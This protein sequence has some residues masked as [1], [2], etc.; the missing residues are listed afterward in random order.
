MGLLRKLIAVGEA[1]GVI[2]IALI[3]AVVVYDVTARAAGHPTL[4]AL[5]VSGY[6]MVAAS[7]LAAGEVMQKGGHF[8]VRLFLDMLPQSLRSAIDRLVAIVTAVFAVCITAGCVQLVLQT[9]ALGFR[10]PTLLQ[11]PLVVPQSVLLL[12][13]ALLSVAALLRAIAQWRESRTG[14]EGEIAP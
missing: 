3:A 11:V 8:E 4:W 12:G 9:H 6:L 1:A 2:A 10:S 14:N 13:L 7:V 5:E